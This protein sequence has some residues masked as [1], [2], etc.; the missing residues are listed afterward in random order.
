VACPRE[1]WCTGLKGLRERAASA[2]AR[3]RPLCQ[4]AG[5]AAHAQPMAAVGA[6]RA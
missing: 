4:M 1:S 2:Y 5:G 6:V 3:R